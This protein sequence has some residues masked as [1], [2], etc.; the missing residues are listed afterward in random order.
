MSSLFKVNECDLIDAHGNQPEVAKYLKERAALDTERDAKTGK[1]TRPWQFEDTPGFFKQSDPNTDDSKFDLISERM[2]LA[3]E[4]WDALVAKLDELNRN[5]KPNECYKLVFCA[6]HGQGYHNYAIL[7]FGMDAWN[8]KWSVLPGT[9]LPNGKKIVWGPD[10][11]L[12]ELGEKQASEIHDL[13]LR[14]IGS[15]LP[16]PSRFFSS[17]FTR[18][19]MTLIRTW[20]GIAIC[21]DGED[22]TRLEAKKR[23]HPLVKE[24]LRETIG[25][26]LCD[27]RGVMSDFL[28]N[29]GSWGFVLEDGIPDQD[30]LYRDDWRESLSGQS[31]RADS[32][33]Q[34]L[35]EQ[36][37]DD[38]II[39]TA[40]H[41]G[42]IR[43][44]ITATG[45]RQFAVTTAGMLP[46]IIKGTRA[47]A[48]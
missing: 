29:W 18:A 10:P 9:T 23:Y 25:E 32:F 6:R 48:N 36:Y 38:S 30:T 33:L 41:A 34:D 16:I 35:F 40:S 4:S 45:H 27:K 2:G 14:E 5:A 43:A 37:P 12:T 47:E 19:A 11:R 24:S 22:E 13:F 39:Y 7:T 31:L 20:K 42:E 44:L 26:H 15:G 46:M 3:L 17:P 1:L 21:E 28:K 8:K